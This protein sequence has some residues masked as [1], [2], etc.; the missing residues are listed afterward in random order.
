MLL[1][2]PI[3]KEVISMDEK[4]LKQM[5]KEVE[6]KASKN[7]FFSTYIKKIL[8]YFG[9][10]EL[11]TKEKKLIGIDKSNNILVINL[12]DDKIEVSLTKGNVKSKIE[13]QCDIV[14]I[15]RDIIEKEKMKNNTTCKEF[16]STKLYFNPCG[17]L[18]CSDNWNALITYYH[19]KEPIISKTEQI[20]FYHQNRA[21]QYNLIN[22]KLCSKIIASEN[23]NLNDYIEIID[24]SSNFLDILDYI[25]TKVNTENNKT[26]LHFEQEINEREKLKK[27]I[28]K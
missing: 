9:N 24:N 15:E 16:S 22:D 12:E 14:N 4:L 20:S 7:K 19:K 27:L 13:L 18:K 11:F 1:Y 17:E 26:D 8:W 6:Q 2:L 28:F 10:V 25:T 3:K 23:I 5:I 21:Y